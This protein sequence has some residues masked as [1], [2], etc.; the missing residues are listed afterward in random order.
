MIIC[1]CKGVSHRDVDAAIAAGAETV[2]A[3]GRTCGAGTGCRGCV[4]TLRARLLAARPLYT[5]E[6][7][8][9]D[10]WGVRREFG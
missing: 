8:P 1:L 2:A 10:P 6:P 5:S 3:I 4:G 9:R 7:E